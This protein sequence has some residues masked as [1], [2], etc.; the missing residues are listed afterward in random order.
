[1]MLVK[2]RATIVGLCPGTTRQMRAAPLGNGKPVSSPTY[3][4]PSGPRA[5]E[6]GTACMGI[7]V[8]GGRPRNGGARTMRIGKTASTV[9]LPS[10]P[11]RSRSL[12]PASATTAM[13]SLIAT[14]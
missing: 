2:P 9:I 3:Q 4:A 12:P 1:M 8:P 5:T 13:P 14:A 6:S 10:R 11:T 7:L